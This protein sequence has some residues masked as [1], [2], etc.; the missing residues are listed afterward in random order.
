MTRTPGLLEF[1]QKHACAS[2]GRGRPRRQIQGPSGP[3]QIYAPQH[4][5]CSPSAST[6]PA[7]GGIEASLW[8]SFATATWDSTTVTRVEIWPGRST[9]WPAA[10]D[11][12][13]CMV[14]HSMG[15]RAAVLACGH[16]AVTAVAGLATWI[17]PEDGVGQAA[18]R[19]VMLA[20]GLRDRVTD[21]AAPTPSR[22]SCAR[23]APGHAGSRSLGPVTPCS[24]ARSVWHAL[25]R[26]FAFGALGLEPHDESASPKPSTSR[27]TVAAGCWYERRTSGSESPC[28]G[29]GIAGLTAAYV[30]SRTHHVTLFEQDDRVGGHAHT[31]SVPHRRRPRAGARHRL[32]R[33]ESAHL[34][35]PAAPVLRAGRADPGLRHVVRGALRGLRPRVRRRPRADR[36]VAPQ[37]RHAGTARDT[38][39]CWPRSSCSTGTPGGC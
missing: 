9:A 3:T 36:C 23:P 29:S 6:W 33:H 18:G 27:P 26:D 16:P 4:C 5:E 34:P 1:G 21:P 14:G 19:T 17:T 2:G 30:I 7:A 20:H 35:H 12:P 11:A 32:H 37:L 22:C 13:I 10:H 25:T 38:C 39:G 28:I 15:A 24:T 8:R 31:V